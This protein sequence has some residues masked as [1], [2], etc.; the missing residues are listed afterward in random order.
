MA[1]GLGE[2]KLR[3]ND[4]SSTRIHI[5]GCRFP[6]PRKLLPLSSPS[7]LIYSVRWDQP[8]GG[9]NDELANCYIRETGKPNICICICVVDVEANTLVLKVDSSEE[10]GCADY[11]HHWKER[12]RV[13]Y[14]MNQQ[15]NS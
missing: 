11:T 8:I 13:L 2:R 1:R 9:R 14:A 7:V 15:K 4:A 5:S 12:K 10:G 6:A 3:V